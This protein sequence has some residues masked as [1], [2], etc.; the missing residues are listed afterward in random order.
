[1]DLKQKKEILELILKVATSLKDKREIE[2]NFEEEQAILADL[3]QKINDLYY[4][5]ISQSNILISLGYLRSR[6]Y[7]LGKIIPIND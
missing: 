4:F 1:M 3:E 5:T 6:L 7:Y 2:Q